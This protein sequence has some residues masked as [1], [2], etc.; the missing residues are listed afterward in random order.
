MQTPERQQKLILRELTVRTY[1]QCIYIVLTYGMMI[2]LITF[3]YSYSVIS[4][5]KAGITP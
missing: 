1:L 3:M 4:A 2:M 5:D